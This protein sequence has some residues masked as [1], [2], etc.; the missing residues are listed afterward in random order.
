M[1]FT[2]DQYDRIRA[3]GDNLDD[4]WFAMREHSIKPIALRAV[5]SHKHK[6]TAKTPYNDRF[7]EED[8]S[9]TFGLH[10]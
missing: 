8:A 1:A 7:E 10:L 2:A 4:V 6:V 3:V 9:G 5:Q